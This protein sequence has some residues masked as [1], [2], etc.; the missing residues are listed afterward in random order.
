MNNRKNGNG[1]FS[2]VPNP[3]RKR[4]KTTGSGVVS[5]DVLKRAEN[6]I[7]K[8]ADDYL[9]WAKSDL[10]RLQY[11]YEQLIE[12]VDNRQENLDLMYTLVHDM[13]GQ[14][15]TFGYTL[16]TRV[17]DQLCRFIDHLD[18]TVSISLQDETIQIH[19]DAM[20]MVLTSKIRGDGGDLG[21]QVLKG[22]EA[23]Q[24]KIRR[25]KNK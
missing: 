1:I 12:N 24:K 10:I 6:V 22:I 23:V 14:G 17:G 25:E 3:I 9:D 5:A 18:D 19:I 4:V 8:L 7:I 2:S 20:R 11:T 21:K 15:G 16:M 13:K